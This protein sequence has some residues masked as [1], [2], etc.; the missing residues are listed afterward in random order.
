ML[1]LIPKILVF[2]S[3]SQLLCKRLRWKLRCCW[4]QRYSF[5]K[6][7]HNWKTF[8]SANLK[9]VVDTK[10]TRFWKQFT[11][12]RCHRLAKC[13][14]LLIPKILVFESNSQLGKSIGPILSCCCW[15][16]RYSFLKAIHNLMSVQLQQHG[17][18]VDTKDTRFWKQFTTVRKIDQGGTALLLVPNILVLESNKKLVFVI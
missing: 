13:L 18:V 4:Y 3:N 9:V 14:L 5:L 11:T 10:D 1:L 8:Y 7:I 6:A 16:Q 17:V 15:Y 2:E 12:S